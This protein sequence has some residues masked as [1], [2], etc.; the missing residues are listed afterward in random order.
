MAQVYVPVAF[1]EKSRLFLWH[2]SLSLNFFLFL[3][4]TSPIWHIKLLY[5]QGSVSGT[6]VLFHLSAQLYWWQYGPILLCLS[7]LLFYPGVQACPYYFSTCIIPYKLWILC[8]VWIKYYNN[9]RR[10]SIFELLRLCIQGTNISSHVYLFKCLS[11]PENF[12]PLTSICSLLKEK[13][14]LSKEK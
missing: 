1:T 7:M 6:V 12:F 2:L 5:L 14:S 13:K 10:I 3:N 9:L 4:S 11:L 8:Q